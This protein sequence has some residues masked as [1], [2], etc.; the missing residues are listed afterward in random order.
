MTSTPQG[1]LAGVRVADFSR[2]LAGPLATMTLGDLGAEVIKIER[3]GTGD[4]T[5][6][7]VPPT[8]E[9][10]Q[11]TYFLAV[12]RNKRSIALDLSTSEGQISARSLALSCDVV[13]ENFA[14]GTM[15]RFGLGYDELA[16]ERPSLVYA[17]VTGFGRKS[18]APGYDF[19]VQA[20][21]GLM[22]VTGYPDGEPLKAGVAIVDVLAGANLATGIIAA[23]LHRERTG[24]GQRV[25]V[26]L[27]SSLLHGLVNQASA[28]LNA[29]VVP[30]RMGN[31]H[32]SVAPYQTLATADRPLAVAV[33]NDG[34]F[35]RLASVLDPALADDPRFAT[36]SSR[37]AHLV[38][39]TVELE[40]RLRTRPASYWI[41]RLSAASVPC[42]LVNTVPEGFALAESVG[43]EPV[44]ALTGEDGQTRASVASPIGLSR[45]PASYRLAPPPLPQ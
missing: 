20:V 19:L 30:R 15:E 31:A 8:T 4:E 41:T 2:V 43:L 35:T 45:T 14:P 23:L 9:D 12:N 37:V 44:V 1:P 26:N 42:G 18:P 16:Q 32:P 27:L 11:S 36:N 24:L 40:R 33:G 7:W 38:E 25:D 13:V 22:S 39:L 21:G 34:Q 17:S 5:R 10:G 6:S 28:H 29:G 3:P